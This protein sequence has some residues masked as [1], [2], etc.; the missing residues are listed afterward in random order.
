MA[1]LV[2]RARRGDGPAFLLCTTY[3]FRGHHVGDVSREYYRAKQEEQQWTAERDPIEVLRAHMIDRRIVDRPGL[4]R[5]H[6]EL[7]SEMDAA[8]Q[9]AIDAPYPSASEVTEDVYA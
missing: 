8:V 4:D 9:W 1:P 7:A 2:E 5:I 6:A 3:R